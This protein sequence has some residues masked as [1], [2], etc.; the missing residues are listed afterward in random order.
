MSGDRQADVAGDTIVDVKIIK[1]GG[2]L[3]D[4]RRRE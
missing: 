1:T 3:M 4:A 2:T